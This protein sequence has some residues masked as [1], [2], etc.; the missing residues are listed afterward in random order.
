MNID[1]EEAKG[2]RDREE[3]GECGGRGITTCSWCDG[4][5]SFEPSDLPW[6]NSSSLK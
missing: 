2:E 6:E 3:C 1:E 5:K 4:D